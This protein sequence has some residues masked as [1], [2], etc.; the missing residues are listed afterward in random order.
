METL[1][2]IVG[3]EGVSEMKCGE[4]D[5]GVQPN[6][7]ICAHCH[8]GWLHPGIREA[9]PDE[10]TAFRTGLE[11]LCAQ[12]RK[13]GRNVTPSDYFIDGTGRPYWLVAVEDN[14]PAAARAKAKKYKR[15]VRLFD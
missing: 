11:T 12:Q 13:E 1:F 2:I 7:V 3:A 15:C 10:H 5:N 14:A 8:N 6:D 9:T 4:C